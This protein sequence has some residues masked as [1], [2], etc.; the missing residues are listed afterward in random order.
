MIFRSIAIVLLCASLAHARLDTQRYGELREA[1]RYQMDVAE[2]QLKQRKWDAALAEFEKFIT[3]YQS[4]VGAPYA[5][6]QIAYCQEQ[7]DFINQ[8]ILEY[9]AL[10]A[11]FPKSPEAPLSAVAIGRCLAKTG[12][13]EQAAQ[14]YLAVVESYPKDPA[15]GDALWEASEIQ[16]DHELYDKALA[17]RQRLVTNYPESSRFGAAVN[18]LIDHHLFEANNLEAARTASNLTREPL[19]TERYLAGQLFSRGYHL[20]RRNDDDAVK[21]LDLAIEV[22]DG[23]ASQFA[24]DAEQ[25]LYARGMIA[26]CHQQAGRQSEATAA[27]EQLLEAYPEADK[28]RGTY[29]SYLENLDQWNEARLQYL[30]YDDKDHGAYE[31]AASYHRQCEVPDAEAAYMRVVAND[32]QRTQVALYQIGRLHQDVSKDYEKAINAYRQSEYSAPAHLFRIAEC[33]SAMGKH[34]MAV[35]TLQE[36]IGFFPDHAPDAMWRMGH[37]YENADDADSAIKT[38][39]RLCDSHPDSRQSSWAHQRLETQYNI[40][41]TGGGVKK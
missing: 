35:K 32:P 20:S 38:F 34:D 36:I 39:K 7:R 26:R 10:I 41:Y 29:A 9:K 11:Y 6:Y 31:V 1:E 8:A 19:Q 3:L 21:W 5:Q 12:E 28:W 4:S 13:T 15:A 27:Y 16:L 22:Y 25:V 37:C 40:P 33:F 14:Q 30:R 18:W 17:A 24:D 23:I 2:A